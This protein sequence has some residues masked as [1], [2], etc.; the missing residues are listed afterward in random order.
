MAAI[1]RNSLST[2]NLFHQFENLSD[3]KNLC[4]VTIHCSNGIFYHNKLVVGLVFPMVEVVD[5]FSRFA[6]VVIIMP[7]ETV[8]GIN[9]RIG[10]CL[11]ASHEEEEEV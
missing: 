5:E 9:V 3:R 1:I 4:N 11:K 7:G 8:Q 6:E 2:S 10:K